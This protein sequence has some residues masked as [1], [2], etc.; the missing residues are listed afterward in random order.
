[1]RKA[2]A[3]TGLLV[4]CLVVWAGA[5]S[6][7]DKP[8]VADVLRFRPL[9][10]G[11]NYSTPSA[12]EQAACTVEL[13][14][15]QRG[16]TGW[17]VRDP[18]GRPLRRFFDSNGD[19][20][21][22]IWSYYLDGAEVYR[23]IDSN[24]DRTADQFR[25]LNANGMKWGVDVNQDG[26]IDTW[27]VISPEEVS[28]EILQALINRDFSR[29]QALFLTE[30]DMKLLELPEA[31]VSRIQSLQRQASAKF[32]STAGRL[33][34]LGAKTR[35][36]HLET[37]APQCLPAET[38]GTKQDLI[39]HQ[40]GTILC[41]TDG[42]NDWIQTG[43]LIQVGLAWRI[44]DAPVA[45]DGASDGSTPGI[46][47]ALQALLDQLR[48]H[49]A[50]SPKGTEGGANAE[51]A[52]YNLQRANLL[53]QIIT[54]VKPEERD[55]WLRQVADCYSAAAQNSPEGDRTAYE[56]LVQLESQIV[57]ESPGSPLAAYVTFRE[58]SAENTARLAKPTQDIGKLQEVWLQ[59]LSGFVSTYPH[60]EDTP[61]A[62][63]QLGMVSEFVSKEN[64]AKKWYERLAKDFAEHPLAGKAQGALRRLDLEGKPLELAGPL[65]QGGNFNIE[66]LRGKTVVVYYW[67]S[68][69]KERSIG[70]FAVLKVLLDKYASQGLELVCVNLDNTAA[71]ATAFLQQTQAPGVHL[72]REGGLESPLATQYGVMVLPNLFLV[73]KEGKVVSRAVQ[74]VNHLEEELKKRLN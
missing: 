2:S 35:W 39:K 16:G 19:N 17:L 18:Q 8:T 73:D 24:F 5:A 67:A 37:S 13:V 15:G 68:W 63:M 64:E 25:W 32:E 47:P 57:K 31:E 65:L 14:T 51:I 29:L 27:R 48:E 59:K 34:N 28:Q 71:D 9:Q 54:K 21:I 69:N 20:H 3:R 36:L 40:R 41:E 7:R 52:N 44:I 12:Q 56:R 49:D 1:M 10:Q 53:Q 60:A 23:E 33:T 46:D 72:Y 61:E 38:L 22:D 45:G 50:K 70:D 6:A 4:S 74:Q 43:E 26:K 11:V 42:K 55:Q 62:L 58:M 66:Q 30:A